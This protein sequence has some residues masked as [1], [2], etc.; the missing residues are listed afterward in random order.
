MHPYRLIQR[1]QWED[2]GRVRVTL[3]SGLRTDS[4]PATEISDSA[5]PPDG[6]WSKEGDR[7][8][9]LD[10]LITRMIPAQFAHCQQ[11]IAQS[12]AHPHPHQLT[13]ILRNDER[14]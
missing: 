14:F 12:Q 13:Q 10:V 9:T 5:T 8:P 2:S 11:T 4:F 6:V 7:T 3:G 1:L